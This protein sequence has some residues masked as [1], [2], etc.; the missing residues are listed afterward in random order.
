MNS[1][2]FM[3]RDGTVSE[4]VGYMRDPEQFRLIPQSAE[5][6]RLIN[7]NSLKSIVITNQSGVARGYFSEETVSRVHQ[8]MEKL[9]SELGAHIDGIYY[10]PH[11]P[12]GIVESYRKGCDCRKPASG[13]L[14]QA[15]K[16][17]AI[18]LASSY[19]VGDKVTD[20]QLA[21]GV[22]ARAVLV[23]TGYGRD[24]LEKIKKLSLKKPEYVACNLLD[25]VKWI[26]KDLRIDHSGDSDNK[27]ECN[28]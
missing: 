2:V 12:E 13:L 7:E 28:R 16:K 22:G 1:A 23:L 27:I 11:H 19:M 21:H 14:T 26:I 4:E 25:A 15:S 3:D 10:C 6:I 17:H 5:A 24:E 18:D 9:L 8:K 20:L